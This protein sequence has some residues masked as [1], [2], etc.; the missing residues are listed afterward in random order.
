MLLGARRLKIPLII[1]STGTAGA[2]PHLLWGYDILKEIAEEEN[3]KF[4]VALIHS[5]QDK[6]YLQKIGRAHV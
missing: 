6:A 3:L 4:K 5:E 2:D 1:G